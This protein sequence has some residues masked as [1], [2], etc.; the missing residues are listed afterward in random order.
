MKRIKLFEDFDLP[1]TE[2][3]IDE[4]FKSYFY[5]IPKLTFEVKTS[6]IKRVN[7]PVL[8]GDDLHFDVNEVVLVEVTPEVDFSLSR[9]Q[10]LRMQSIKEKHQDL[11]DG[12]IDISIKSKS[13]LFYIYI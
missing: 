11:F 12:V 8:I 2:K 9:V 13:F 10:I 1:F 6:P 3:E 7:D 5:D 4:I